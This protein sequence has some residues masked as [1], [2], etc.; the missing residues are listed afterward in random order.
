MSIAER[1]ASQ[2][3]GYYKDYSVKGAVK[4][5]WARLQFI[6]KPKYYTANYN[7]GTI[8]GAD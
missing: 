4:L 7:S 1:I 2:Y 3:M 5:K 6:S 8:P